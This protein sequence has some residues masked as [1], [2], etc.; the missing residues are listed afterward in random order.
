ML[1]AMLARVT[2]LDTCTHGCACMLLPAEGQLLDAAAAAVDGITLLLAR[3]QACGMPPGQAELSHLWLLD[4]TARIFT[5]LAR[6]G[7]AAD[8][9]NYVSRHVAWRVRMCVACQANFLKCLCVH[10]CNANTPTL[11]FVHVSICACQHVH[12]YARWCARSVLVLVQ[13]A[14]VS[15]RWWRSRLQSQCGLQWA[16]H[17]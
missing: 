2:V 7:M 9:L 14:G 16:M 8:F 15:R 11:E 3:Q 1:R 17:W 10:A 5:G 13:L 12:M 4:M 6:C